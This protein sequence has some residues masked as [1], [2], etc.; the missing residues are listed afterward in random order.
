M[1]LVKAWIARGRGR[2]VSVTIGNHVLELSDVGPDQQRVIV[3][4][5][6]ATV[7]QDGTN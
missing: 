4:E 7:H 2:R 5:F 1:Q 6:F 3:E